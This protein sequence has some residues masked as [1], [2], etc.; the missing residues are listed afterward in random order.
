ME[1]VDPLVRSSVVVVALLLTPGNLL[2][3]TE[4]LACAFLVVVVISWLSRLLYCMIEIAHYITLYI[5]KVEKGEGVG[6][7]V[8]EVKV[9]IMIVLSELDVSLNILN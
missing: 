6:V 8:V 3:V 4:E 1:G 2:Q 9:C 5:W 7:A